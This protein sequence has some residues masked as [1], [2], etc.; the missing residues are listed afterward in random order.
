MP[1]KYEH[2]IFTFILSAF[3]GLIFYNLIGAVIFLLCSL[4]TYDLP[5]KIERPTSKFHRKFYHSITF[6]VILFLLFGLSFNSPF[7]G[8]LFGYLTHLILDYSR[9]RHKPLI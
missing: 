3:V 9:G 8:V 4:I 5:D 2:L 7:S 1:K 6:F